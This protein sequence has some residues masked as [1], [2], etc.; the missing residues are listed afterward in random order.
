MRSLVLLT[1]LAIACGGAGA[2]T[3]SSIPTAGSPTALAPA[4]TASPAD[5]GVSADALCFLAADLV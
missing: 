5:T 1:V 3:A 4:T 2:P